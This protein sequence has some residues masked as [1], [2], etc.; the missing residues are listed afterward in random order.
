MP[1]QWHLNQK[2]IRIV[3]CE[4]NRTWEIRIVLVKIIEHG[5]SSYILVYTMISHVLLFSPTQFKH[6]NHHHILFSQLYNNSHIEQMIL[7]IAQVT[8]II[9]ITINFMT[10]IITG[11]CTCKCTYRW[12]KYTVLCNINRIS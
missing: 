4:N 9:I 7:L 12:Q 8:V 5:K 6:H 10:V 2:K 3:L 1:L 11:L